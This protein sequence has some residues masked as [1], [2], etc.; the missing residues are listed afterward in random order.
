MCTFTAAVEVQGQK[1]LVVSFLHHQA[2]Q[3]LSHNPLEQQDV[4][5]VTN[6]LDVGLQV[7][8][9]PYLAIKGFALHHFVAWPC[10]MQHL[11]P[12]VAHEGSTQA[13]LFAEL[14]RR[15]DCF[16]AC[17]SCLAIFV[18]TLSSP[19]PVNRRQLL[20]SSPYIQCTSCSTL[21]YSQSGHVLRKCA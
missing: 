4:V 12:D 7:P 10:Q 19:L 11:F 14:S 20:L 15:R 18:H 2:V 1:Q 3:R 17:I 6:Y 8:S 9:H 21:L 13:N 16:A 5:G